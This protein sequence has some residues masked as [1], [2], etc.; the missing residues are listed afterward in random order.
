[1]NVK[2]LV[3]LL[4]VAALAGCAW[5]PPPS[6]APTTTRGV[7]NDANLRPVTM[8]YKD[9]LVYTY[10]ETSAQALCHA[11]SPQEWRTLLGGEVGRTVENYDE[12]VVGNSSLTVRMSMKLDEPDY[13]PDGRETELIGGYPAWIESGGAVVTLVEEPGSMWARPFLVVGLSTGSGSP[14]QRDLLRRLVTTLLGKLAH[15]GPATPVEGAD[16]TLAFVPT[17]PVP[18]VRLID[19][20]WPVRALV[21]C[22]A[23]VATGAAQVSSVDMAGQCAAD[24]GDRTAADG[25]RT[26]AV[27]G[28][29]QVVKSARFKVGGR[30]AWFTDYD[31]IVI[32]LA[33]LP[34]D[35]YGRESHLY[36]KLAWSFVDR[37]ATKA[38]AN[39]FVGQLGEL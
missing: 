21:L 4:A 32:D 2:V 39:Q 15:D 1:M 6:T 26:A 22:T 27:T 34:P 31:A 14:D 35:G 7:P 13:A 11:L 5:D 24:D 17:Q 33:E 10:G 37:T 12:C 8:T 3:L 36:L 16:D 25:H 20:P 29:D 19:L 9:G 23:M 28:E 30:L 18:G 38:W